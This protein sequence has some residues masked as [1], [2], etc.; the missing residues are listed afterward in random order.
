MLE[1]TTIADCMSNFV[2]INPVSVF[3]FFST[4]KSV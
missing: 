2:F 4:V 1:I 3:C